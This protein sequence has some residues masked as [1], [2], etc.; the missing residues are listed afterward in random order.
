M[1]C[2]NT[3][4]IV[5]GVGVGGEEGEVG[6]KIRGWRRD[7]REGGDGGFLFFGLVRR[8]VEGGGCVF[9]GWVRGFFGGGAE[10]GVVGGEGWR[11]RR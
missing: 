9:C 10:G 7:R 4:L 8:S 3:L 11:R 1:G 5:G 2:K 6:C